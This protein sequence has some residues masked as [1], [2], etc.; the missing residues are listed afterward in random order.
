MVYRDGEIG[1]ALGLSTQQSGVAVGQEEDRQRV[2]AR[3]VEHMVHVAIAECS[4]QFWRIRDQPQGA[5]IRRIR[6]LSSDP[7]QFGIPMSDAAKDAESARMLRG[8]RLGQG[9]QW[10]DF[11]VREQ[12]ARLGA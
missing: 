4:C 7:T 5:A 6:E 3:N 10:S 1:Q 2:V 12:F 8:G 9:T 11:A